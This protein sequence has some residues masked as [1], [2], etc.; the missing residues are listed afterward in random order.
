MVQETVRPSNLPRKI[1]PLSFMTSVRLAE[2]LE[3]E[4]RAFGANFTILVLPGVGTGTAAPS[5]GVTTSGQRSV[6]KC[7]GLGPATT[8]GI[9]ALGRLDLSVTV[10]SLGA[11]LSG[12]EGIGLLGGRK[13]VRH[14]ASSPGVRHCVRNYDLV[15]RLAAR[16]I[17]RQMNSGRRGWRRLTSKVTVGKKR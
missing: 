15:I 7:L 12:G 2:K 8:G 5:L 10:L 9:I 14:V 16:M 6:V 3:L 17:L 1:K 13:C 4:I 11:L